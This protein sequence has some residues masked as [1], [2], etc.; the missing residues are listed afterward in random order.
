MYLN[1]VQEPPIK[2][3]P[4]CDFMEWI[5]E[6]MSEENASMVA[7]W[8]KWQEEDDIRARECQAKEKAER[9]RRE[10]LEWRRLAEENREKA[11]RAAERARKVARAQRAKEAGPEA[12]RKGK[13]P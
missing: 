2:P 3:P 13:Y 10:E 8:I 1:V 5:D 12:T 11:K 7:Q 6:K 4:L 9:E